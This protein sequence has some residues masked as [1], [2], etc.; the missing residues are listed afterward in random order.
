MKQIAFVVLSL[1]S[2]LCVSQSWDSQRLP[3]HITIELWPDGAPTDN[4]VD[5]AHLSTDNN[6]DIKP[7]M[8]VFLPHGEQPHHAVII[9]PGGA[10]GGLAMY[11]EGFEWTEY[12]TSHDI[13][14]IV[15]LYRLPHGHHEVPAED[16]YEAIR[17]TQT[18][19]SEW[20]I[21][22]AHIGIMGSSAGGHLASTVATHAPAMLRPAFQILLYPV[23]TTDPTFTHYWSCRNLMGELLSEMKYVKFVKPQ[24]AFYYF[25]DLSDAFGKEYKGKKIESAADAAAILIE[26]YHVVIVPCAD[27]GAP[28][29]FRLSY[30]ISDD[31]IR[32]GLGRLSQFLDDL[33]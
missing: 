11:H 27:F 13:A 24:G 20:H 22:P 8:H 18:H 21:D 14:A 9:C 12:F 6:R 3:H 16:V 19:A 1:I 33:K 4:G 17:L 2:L 7:Q 32:K 31:D 29:C 5:Y 25:V 23:I 28:E 15:L 10:Y 30:A 26:D